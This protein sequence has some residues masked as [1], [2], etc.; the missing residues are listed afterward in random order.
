MMMDNC[1]TTVLSSQSLK[2][3]CQSKMYCV[4]MYYSGIFFCQTKSVWS[5]LSKICFLL[6]GRGNE[7]LELLFSHDY[8]LLWART[9]GTSRLLLLMK[10]NGLLQSS[11]PYG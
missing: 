10:G 11:K 7:D 3:E 9:R 8:T 5:D 1:T 4:A 2:D 6:Q